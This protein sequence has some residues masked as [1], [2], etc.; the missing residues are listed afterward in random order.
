M[1][2]QDRRPKAMI[3]LDAL[4][5]GRRP[6]ELFWV[7][8]EELS[9]EKA[10]DFSLHMTPASNMLFR[11]RQLGVDIRILA[12]EPKDLPEVMSEGLSP[13]VEAA[14]GPAAAMVLRAADEILKTA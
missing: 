2:A 8:I 3:I 6:G 5:A 7:D 4:R 1:V 10:E 9:L 12:C 14:V 13:E 11:L